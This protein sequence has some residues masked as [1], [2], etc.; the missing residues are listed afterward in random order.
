MIICSESSAQDDKASSN[1][2]EHSYRKDDGDDMEGS[3]RSRTVS[4]DISATPKSSVEQTLKSP[5]M[6][7]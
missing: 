6:D 5:M 1:G 3:P 2:S 4:L 7:M